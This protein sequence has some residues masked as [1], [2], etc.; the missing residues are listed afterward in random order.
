MDAL[1]LPTTQFKSEGREGAKEKESVLGQAGAAQAA[2]VGC[3][4]AAGAPPTVVVMVAHALLMAEPPQVP[5]SPH[6]TWRAPGC[7][8]LRWTRARPTR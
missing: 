6:R 5:P 2:C 1:M 7:W 8:V 3:R 4:Q